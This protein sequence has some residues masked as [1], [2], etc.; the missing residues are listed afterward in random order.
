MDLEHIN[1]T[2]GIITGTAGTALLLYNRFKKAKTTARKEDADANLAEQKVRTAANTEEQKIDQRNYMFQ[3][4]SYQEIIAGLQDRLDALYNRVNEHQNNHLLAIANIEEVH[5]ADML[6][7]ELR[8]RKCLEDNA[9]IAREN[10]ELRT[11]LDYLLDKIKITQIPPHTDTPCDN[12]A[13]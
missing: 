10:A 7:I 11:R 4:K 9:T 3:F 12:N 6:R 8:E 13:K 1:Y 2:I 5:K